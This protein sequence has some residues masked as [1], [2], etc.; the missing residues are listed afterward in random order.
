MEI[1][2]MHV[3]RLLRASLDQLRDELR[4]LDAAA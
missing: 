2:Q 1:S 4:T 3:S